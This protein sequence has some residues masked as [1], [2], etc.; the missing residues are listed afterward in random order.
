MDMYRGCIVHYI[1]VSGWTSYTTISGTTQRGRLN[2]ELSCL[3]GGHWLWYQK[4]I[5][6]KLP[7]REL[8]PHPCPSWT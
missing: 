2:L 4:S 8:T 3:G 1:V 7:W 6:P 5:K